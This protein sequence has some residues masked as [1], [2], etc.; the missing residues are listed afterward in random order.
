MF[1]WLVLN[2]KV[3]KYVLESEM[4]HPGPVA[5]ALGILENLCLSCWVFNDPPQ[6]MSSSLSLGA[7]SYSYFF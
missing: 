4:M 1:L 7:I 5:S 3:G 6:K 2:Y